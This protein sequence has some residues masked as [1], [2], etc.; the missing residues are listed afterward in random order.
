MKT[1]AFTV[2]GLLKTGASAKDIAYVRDFTQ[3]LQYFDPLQKTQFEYSF[4]VRASGLDPTVRV[5][6]MD[7]N[8][9]ATRNT[10]L[11]SARMDVFE[12]ILKRYSSNKET[13]RI[14]RALRN[15][16]Q[17]PMDLYFGVDS[18]QGQATYA[19]WL[20]FGG[21]K[22]DGKLNYVSY[23]VP[24][25]MRDLLKTSGM[26]PPKASPG[27]V[28]NFGFD[29]GPKECFYKLYYLCDKPALS[30]RWRPVITRVKRDLSGYKSFLFRSELFNASGKLLKEKLFV[31]FLE[32]VWLSPRAS[33]DGLMQGLFATASSLGMMPTARRSESLRALKAIGGRLGLVSFEQDGTMTFYIRA[34]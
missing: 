2:N 20:V 25:I 27:R 30:A 4:K 3:V 15:V 31:E 7:A 18:L 22:R 16:S 6:N 9:Y 21:V 28:L 5:L 34:K 32:D 10:R 23:N 1:P 19:F 14:V 17:T 29:V 13:A 24:A 12:V 26:K 33:L 11:F 8:G